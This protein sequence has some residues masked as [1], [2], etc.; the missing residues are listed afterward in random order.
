LIRLRFLPGLSP[1]G[2]NTKSGYL[3]FGGNPLAC[4]VGL[5][6]LNTLLEE[7]L[8]ERS[9]HLG[10]YML[11]RLRTL[12]S[13]LLKEVRGRGLFV[14]IEVHGERTNARAVCEALLAEG[15]LSKETQDTVV[16]FAPPLIIERAQ[17]DQAVD[18]LRRALKTLERSERAA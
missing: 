15:V 14:G 10:A 13:P 6:A 18:G 4:A 17:I 12:D 8:I 3:T 9:A 2:E 7:G 5:E 16:R 11:Q 1:F